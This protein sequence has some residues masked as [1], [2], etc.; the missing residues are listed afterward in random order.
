MDQSQTYSDVCDSSILDLEELTLGVDGESA[1]QLDGSLEL[2]N[3]YAI[4]RLRLE[5]ENQIAEL[6]KRNLGLHEEG[7][8]IP[9]VTY[10]RIEGLYDFYNQPGGGYFV[11]RDVTDRTPIGGVGLAPLAELPP[12]EGLLEIRDLIIYK[13]YRRLGFGGM[14]LRYCLKVAALEGYKRVYLETT[15]Q[16][17]NAQSFFERYGFTPVVSKSQKV[18]KGERQI[19]SYYMRCLEL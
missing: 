14:L 18:E 17:Q 15:P 3:R 10:R 16:M 2:N 11:L 7:S 13:P 5:E 9:E 4:D 1:F 12:S 6:M 8:E 19:P